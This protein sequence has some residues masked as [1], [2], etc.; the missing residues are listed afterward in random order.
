MLLILLFITCA[1][2]F[3]Y[4]PP[5]KKHPQIISHRGASGYVPEHSLAAYQLAIDLATDYIEPDLCVSK[6][7]KLCPIVLLSSCY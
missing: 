3:A 1:S 6:D 2:I 7:G 5:V 4:L